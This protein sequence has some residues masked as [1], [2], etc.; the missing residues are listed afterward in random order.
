MCVRG[1]GGGAVGV[2]S[3]G[4]VFPITQIMRVSDFRSLAL[5]V[6][7]VWLFKK[8]TLVNVTTLVTSL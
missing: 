4:S 3:F 8:Y 6:N 5:M 1:G 2:N 7:I